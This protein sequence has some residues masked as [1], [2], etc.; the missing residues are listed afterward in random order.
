MMDGFVF[1]HEAWRPCDVPSGHYDILLFDPSGAQHQPLYLTPDRDQ[2]VVLA[3]TQTQGWYISPGYT[4]T[5]TSITEYSYDVDDVTESTTSWRYCATVREPEPQWQLGAKALRHAWWTKSRKAVSRWEF[6]PQMIHRDG[7]SLWTVDQ[8]PSQIQTVAFWCRQ[9]DPY[10]VF[11]QIKDSRFYF[12]VE[13]RQT[14]TFDADG[15]TLFRLK[16][17]PASEACNIWPTE[18]EASSDEDEL[19]GLHLLDDNK[20]PSITTKLHNFFKNVLLLLN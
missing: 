16:P 17:Q 8:V 2:A 3:P 13:G 15:M 9:E 14:V 20:N 4:L 7:A 6:R 11:I 5:S 19:L 10:H 18:P 12:R 1:N